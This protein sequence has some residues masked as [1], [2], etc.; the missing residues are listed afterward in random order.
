MMMITEMML[1]FFVALPYVQVLNNQKACG[2][3]WEL[4]PELV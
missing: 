1:V 2:S 4:V 3:V